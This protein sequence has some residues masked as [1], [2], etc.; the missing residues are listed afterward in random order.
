M[1][2]GE[3]GLVSISPAPVAP[4]RLQEEDQDRAWAEK[5]HIVSRCAVLRDEDGRALEELRV[6]EEVV[7]V[8]GVGRSRVGHQEHEASTH[9]M[10]GNL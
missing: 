8:R 6:S 3:Q 4:A 7:S 5:D 10:G 9:I 1:H 2:P